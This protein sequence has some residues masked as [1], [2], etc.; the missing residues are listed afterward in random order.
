M[1]KF[2]SFWTGIALVCL[3]FSVWAQEV[4]ISIDHPETV[5][6][7]EIFEVTVSIDKGSLTDYSRFSQ[8]LP[9]GLTATNVESPNADFS[10]DNQ[11][12]RI[13]WLKLPDVE[14]IKVS[15]N[16]MVDERLKGKFILG[17]VFAYVV[18]EERKFLNFEKSDEITII[19]STT[20]DQAL[21]V[22]IKDFKGGPTGAP[23]AVATGEEPY[24][25]AVR[26]KPEVLSS[27]G[28][29]VK[30]L[31][32]NPSGSKYAKIEEIIPSGY[33]FESIDP[34]DGIESFSSST[35]KFIWM[36]LPGEAEFEVSYRLVPK[37]DEPQG[38]MDIKGELTY[39]A[40]NNNKI[41]PI[42]Q[43]DVDLSSL[44]LADKRNLLETGEIPVSTGLSAGTEKNEKAEK[45]VPVVE[46]KVPP[47]KKAVVTPLPSPA[48]GDVIVN[49]RVLGAESGVYYRVQITANRSAFDAR[50]LY[51]QAG[52]DQEVFVEEHGDFYKYTAGSFTSYDQAVRYRDQ[53]ET[54]PEIEG[55][56]VVSYKDGKRIPIPSNQ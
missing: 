8:D 28:Y 11:R 9:L 45:P 29:F 47:P 23:V 53:L 5:K 49:T 19:P 24:A 37:R 7:G 43:V 13:I 35:V 18:D 22:D 38:E 50:S 36:K 14:E 52:V 34:H 42:K 25:M 48:S 44:S 51:N 56:F 55:A 4:D 12:I 32:K 2:K 54:N 46:K 17:G 21:I 20:I 6:A 3:S 40:G 16:I 33:L 26:Q 41:V 31:I 39:S 1:K 27:G 10:F 30:V 15:Y